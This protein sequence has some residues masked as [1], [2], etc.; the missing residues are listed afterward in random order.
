MANEVLVKSVKD[1]AAASK[2]GETEKAYLGYRDLFASEAFA[3]YRVEDQRQALRL[4][5]MAKGLPALPTPAMRAAYESAVSC[6]SRLVSLGDAADHELLG[7][8]QVML[9]DE[10]GASATFRAGLAI[11]R[12]RDPQSSLCGALM[13]RVSMV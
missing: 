10:S 9:G 8:C 5:V 11:E 4:M 3:T 1:I 2:A 12:A 6:L 13:K 7:M